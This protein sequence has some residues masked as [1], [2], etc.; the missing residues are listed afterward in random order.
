MDKTIYLKVRKSDIKR[1]GVVRVND[2]VLTKLGIQEGERVVISKDEQMIIRKALGDETVKKDEIFLRSTARNE[3][4]VKEGDEVKVEDYET[5]GEEIKEKLGEV[6]E[7]IGKG[8]G[9]IKERFKK[10]KEED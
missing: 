1:V 3:L 10:E 4:D 7:K 6:K 8:V 2:E 9:K 5:I